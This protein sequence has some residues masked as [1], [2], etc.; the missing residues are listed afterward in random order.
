M[1]GNI[2]RLQASTNECQALIATDTGASPSGKAGFDPAMRW[3][4]SSRPCHIQDLAL[5]RARLFKYS[6]NAVRS[7]AI[8]LKTNS[9]KLKT[10]RISAGH[11]GSIRMAGSVLPD[12][13]IACETRA[14][15]RT[16]AA[17][18]GG[19]PRA[20]WVTRTTG[21]RPASDSHSHRPLS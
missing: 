11:A 1:I 4:K 13:P 3:F 20:I 19:V 7:D 16:P 2:H 18:S 14:N 6:V 17:V 15:W 5:H 12:Q 21:S 9:F 8:A 10:I